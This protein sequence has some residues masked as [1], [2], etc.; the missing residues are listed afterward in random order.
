MYCLGGEDIFME[1]VKGKEI[2][3]WSAVSVLWYCSK[4][5][6]EDML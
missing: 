3:W 4:E 1:E 6:Q 5:K 2:N